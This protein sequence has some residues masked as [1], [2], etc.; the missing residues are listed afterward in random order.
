MNAI[1]SIKQITM[2][3]RKCDGPWVSLKNAQ[4][5]IDERDKWKAAHDNQVELKRIIS[6]RPDLGDRA[7]L[8]EKLMQENADL[9]K[10]LETITE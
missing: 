10:K 5:L 7:I 3:C 4:A 8:V 2:K 9:L 1:T 6:A